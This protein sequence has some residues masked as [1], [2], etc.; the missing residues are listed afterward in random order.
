[1][2]QCIILFV[3]LSLL[4]GIQA[5][6]QNVGVGTSTPHASAMLHV[7][8]TTKGF[9]PPRV[10][11]T[12]RNQIPS[13]LNGLMVYE[14][15]NE[16]LFVHTDGDWKFLID[17]SYWARSS[18]RGRVYN[19]SD[20]IG[21]GTAAPTE[22]LSLSNGN[23]RILNGDIK[24]SNGDMY[25]NKEDVIIQFQTLGV[26]KGFL[27]LAGDNLRVGTNSSNTEGKFV[28]RVGGSDR[29]L[30]DNTGLSVGTTS[31]APGYM[32][33]VGGKMICEEVKVKLEGSWPDY[34]FDKKYS[35]PTLPELQR[36]IE[37]NKH[38]PNIPPAS[39]IEKNGVELGDMQRKMMEKIE[40]LTL[41]ILQL[42]N[43]I[44]TLKKT[45]PK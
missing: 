11:L 8:S 1:M 17:N 24:M 30:V 43:E 23:F 12:Q 26:D 40:E 36:F 38:L 19:G 41:Y 27:Q 13:P 31:A 9:L 22:R 16:K 10:T 32:F 37:E 25:M 44:E 20:S 18:T 34:V 3:F 5:Q 29:I 7:N 2:K 14:T 45:L 6:N 35:L 4:S 21:I 28:V 42:H 33:R 15:D 39:I